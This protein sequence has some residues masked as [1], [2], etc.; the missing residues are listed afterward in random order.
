MIMSA[1]MEVYEMVLHG[2][3]K[4]GLVK[5][6]KDWN[7]AYQGDE[8]AAK[9]AATAVEL[10]YNIIGRSITENRVFDLE[11]RTF[12]TNIITSAETDVM[13]LR[14]ATELV[15]ILISGNQC[16][17]VDEEINSTHQETKEVYV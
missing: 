9:L 3:D 15:K 8:G 6:I 16:I 7:T 17:Y 13:V 12:N 14:A 4:H 5:M 2:P 10:G 1:C 11:T